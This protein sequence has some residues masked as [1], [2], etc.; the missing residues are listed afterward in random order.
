MIINALLYINVNANNLIISN[1]S[2]SRG[3]IAEFNVSIVEAPNDVKS[4]GFD[5]EYPH[6]SLSFQ[7][8]D[9]DIGELFKN[10]VLAT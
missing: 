10:R 2:S 4:F 5:I 9:Y 8:D 6:N 3:E 7:P 1:E